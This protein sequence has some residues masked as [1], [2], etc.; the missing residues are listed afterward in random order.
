[1]LFVAFSVSEMVISAE[2][3][4]TVIDYHII[5][6]IIISEFTKRHVCLQKACHKCTL[7]DIYSELS[8][9][10]SILTPH[11]E[12]L[13]TVLILQYCVVFYTTIGLCINCVRSLHKCYFTYCIFNCYRQ[14]CAKHS[15]ASIVFT[16]WYK[17]GFSPRRGDTLPR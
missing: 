1:M 16:Q 14:A 13:P 8:F 15:H 11:S 9:G 4:T 12:I 6:I 7:L 5:I 3:V 17:K 10:A 2:P